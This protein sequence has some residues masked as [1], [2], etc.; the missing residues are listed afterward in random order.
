MLSSISTV[1]YSRINLGGHLAEK[2]LNI[3]VSRKSVV[4]FFRIWYLGIPYSQNLTP[5]IILESPIP[6]IQLFSWVPSAPYRGWQKKY[7]WIRRPKIFS[8]DTL[9][10]QSFWK[11][12]ILRI[13]LS[14][15]CEICY[16]NSAGWQKNTL[17][18]KFSWLNYFGTPILRI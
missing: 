16:S 11:T 8:S 2:V 3:N 12:P 9:G 10:A 15:I 6:R 4:N 7:F 14:L 5:P 1:Q 13:H 17:V 18:L